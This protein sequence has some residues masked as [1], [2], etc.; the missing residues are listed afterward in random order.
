MANLTNL[1]LKD[2]INDEEFTEKRKELNSQIDKAKQNLNQNDSRSENWLDTMD[3]AFNFAVNARK[4]FIEGD[5]QAK[6]EI[7]A[8][9][10]QSYTLKNKRL[11][12]D[13]VEWLVPISNLNK[14]SLNKLSRLEPTESS[15]E[16]IQKNL[17]RREIS[18]WGA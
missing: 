14:K 16:S 2:L 10:G 6:R 8:A 5:L 18:L 15:I 3:T 12:I 1:R 11:Y 13:P 17:P 9:L 7:L 4:A